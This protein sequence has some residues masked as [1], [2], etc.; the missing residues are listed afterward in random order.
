MG[1]M[2]RR[3]VKDVATKKK[4]EA[5]QK[6]FQAQEQASEEI[7]LLEEVKTKGKRKE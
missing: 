6:A 4:N 5:A 2:A 3:R 7:P 1:V